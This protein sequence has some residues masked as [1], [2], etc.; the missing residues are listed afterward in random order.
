MFATLTEGQERSTSGHEESGDAISV[1]PFLPGNEYRCLDQF[2]GQGSAWKEEN[3]R[4]QDN[5]AC[6]TQELLMVTPFFV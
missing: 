5:T 3:H 6:A 1:I 2:A 4:Q